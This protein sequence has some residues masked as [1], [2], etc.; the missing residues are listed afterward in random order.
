[1]K[2]RAGDIRFLNMSRKDEAIT[3]APRTKKVPTLE[4]IRFAIDGMPASTDVENRDRALIAFTIV[5]GMRDSAIASLRLKHID[6]DS[7]LVIQ[8]PSE[9]KTKFSKRIETFFFPVGDDLEH[10][11]VD[12]VRYLR[13]VKLWGNDDP[14]FPQTHVA[15]N[16][17]MSFQ[18]LGIKPEFW[19]TAGRIRKIFER[20]FL[21]ADLPYF[22]PHSFRTTLGILG[23][24]ACQTPEE[25]KAWSQNLGHE[26][27]LTTFTSYGQ[28]PT[29][30]QG[31]LIRGA[32]KGNRQ[33]DKIDRLMWMVEKMGEKVEYA[34]NFCELSSAGKWGC[35][36]PLWYHNNI[37]T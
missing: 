19:S 33:E 26:N 37:S 23:E 31:Q 6:L 4:Q 9:V 16:A 2:I 30:R 13:E 10:I 35:L 5:T 8:D 18:V 36:V 3:K 7:L 12:W 17:Q 25:F 24:Q 1:M 14:V 21:A 27:P 11:V 15:P 28:V 20:A 22:T 34:A 32:T 29:H